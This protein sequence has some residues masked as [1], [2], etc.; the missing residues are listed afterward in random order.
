MPLLLLIVCL[1]V[2][3]GNLKLSRLVGKVGEVICAKKIKEDYV[4]S[5]FST[6]F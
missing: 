1:A 4:A 3:Q 6:C 2:C 5:G